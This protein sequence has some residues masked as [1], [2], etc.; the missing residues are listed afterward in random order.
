MA[1]VLKASYLAK[2]VSMGKS[3]AGKV[4]PSKSG[5]MP[6]ESRTNAFH[7]QAKQHLGPS[8]GQVIAG[9]TDQMD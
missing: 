4:S 2:A 3:A 9:M 7:S 8:N 1:G 5:N 6:G